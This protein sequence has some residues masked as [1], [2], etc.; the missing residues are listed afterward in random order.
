MVKQKRK[1]TKRKACFVPCVRL[2]PPARAGLQAA[3]TTTQDLLFCQK[4]WKFLADTEPHLP[5]QW[6]RGLT[7]NLFTNI[8]L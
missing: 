7:L 3:F 6:D 8:K 1:N 5:G 4:E 2:C